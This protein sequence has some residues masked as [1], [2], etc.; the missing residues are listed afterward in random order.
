MLS[1]GDVDFMTKE[2]IIE[3]SVWVTMII[4]LLLFVPKNKLREASSV[5]TFTL[6]L[7]FMFGLFIVQMKWIEYPARILFRYADRTEFTFEFVLY[8]TICVLFV[9]HY[10]WRKNYITQLGYFVAYSSTMTL[11]EVLIE[12]YT[13]L[14]HYIKWTWYWKWITIFLTFY[15]SRLFYVWL[16]RIKVKPESSL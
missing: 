12:H 10:P 9:L 7:G 3:A 15:L 13:Q 6:F 4:A 14:I 11:V 8:P 1:I 5:Y 2:K 16:F